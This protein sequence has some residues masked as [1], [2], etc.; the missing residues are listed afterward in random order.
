MTQRQSLLALLAQV[1]VAIAALIGA[2]VL[3]GMGKLDGEAVVVL[4]TTALTLAGTGASATARAAINGGPRPDYSALAKA[5]P[6][7][8]T[9]LASA[10]HPASPTPEQSGHPHE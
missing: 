9:A 1:G 8:A 5:S 7:A 10:Y 3:A 2:S 4:Y 6:E